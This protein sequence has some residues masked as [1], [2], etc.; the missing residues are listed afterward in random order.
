MK[1]LSKYSISG[2]VASFTASS[3]QVLKGD[4]S[5]PW[6]PTRGAYDEC[7]DHVLWALEGFLGGGSGNLGL[8]IQGTW[9]PSYTASADTRIVNLISYINNGGGTSEFVNAITASGTR[10]RFGVAGTGAN[11]SA[12]PITP[13]LLPPYIRGYLTLAAYSGVAGTLRF[14][15]DIGSNLK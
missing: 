9:D 7:G 2:T 8:G 1:I 6:I 15:I 10:T 4:W 13:M 12:G 11:S 3:I 5:S 14:D